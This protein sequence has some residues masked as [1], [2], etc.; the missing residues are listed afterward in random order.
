M[1]IKIQIQTFGRFLSNMI[2]PN[3]GAFIAWG[4]IT[5]LFIPTGWLP[6]EKLSELVGPMI[7]F[8]LPLLIAYTGGKLVHG[9]RGAL[10]AVVA[11]MG[12]ILSTETMM[13]LGAM[14]LGPTSAY[15]M[16][17]LDRYL[18]PRIPRGFEM[19]V[20]NYSLGILAMVLALLS[21][22]VTGPFVAQLTKA[23]GAGVQALVD[24]QL[25]P[26]T[27]VLVEPAKI[28][29]LNNAINHGIFSPAGVEQAK[30]V[31]RSIYFLI[32]A[33]PGPGLGLLLAYM[34]FGRGQAKETA[35]G[36]VIIHFLGGIHEIYF[37]YV[38]MNPRLLIA[39]IL[40][41]MTGVYTLMYFQAG[42]T[43][44]ASPGSIFAVLTM[45]PKGAHLGVILSVLA[46]AAV[47]FVLS[48]LL[49]RIQG[50]EA[51]LNAAK[52]EMQQLKGSAS[53]LRKIYVACD[54][55]MGSSAMGAGLLRK[56]L[57]EAGLTSIEVQNIA[58][59]DLPSDATLVITH[60]D[61]TPRAQKR[62]PRAQHYALNNFLEHDFYT[63]LVQQL[64][65]SSNAPSA[66]AVTSEALPETPADA[67]S[68]LSASQIF[69]NQKASSK[70]EAIRAVGQHLQDLGYVD[71]AYIDAML[72][73]EALSS[74]YLGE[75]IA[76]PHG[77]AEAKAAVK[78]TGVVLC[79]YPE[80]VPFDDEQAYLLLGIAAND[81]AHLQ[82]IAAFSSALDDEA[83]LKALREAKDVATVLRLLQDGS[84]S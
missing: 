59:N 82:I 4:L 64:S 22:L 17:E 29:F 77:T 37:P 55:G 43:A 6:N 57:N 41:G 50:Q 76:M 58:I 33:N 27:S 66:S 52:E 80:G 3:I 25:L 2:M 72:A 60:R 48:A 1:S 7:R 44:P 13:F 8:L 36:A 74:T 39:M 75:G 45:T 56:K 65:A 73:R 46:S 32:E 68:Q 79:Q 54:A 69:L 71:A 67:V 10:V 83:K 42:L 78:K 53:Q 84:A 21:L 14:I 51:D 20:N 11:T 35:G 30:E 62:V 31:G 23:F 34:V 9:E 28:L 15:L 40:G 24:H 12:A 47:S 16:R 19:L 63:R 26:L 61:L 18:S 70:E 5:A 81:Q 38:L 49:L